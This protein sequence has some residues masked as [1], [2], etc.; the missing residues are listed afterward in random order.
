MSFLSLRRHQEDFDNLR[1]KFGLSRPQNDS[2]APTDSWFQDQANSLLNERIIP[3]L[4][5]KIQE[6]LSNPQTLFIS[7]FSI[8]I[9]ILKDSE[10]Y[11]D[12]DSDIPY[13][14][15]EEDDR[16]IFTFNPKKSKEES[17]SPMT[18]ETLYDCI[19][20]AAEDTE[21]SAE[22]FDFEGMACLE[23]SIEF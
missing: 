8:Q 7:K 13:F 14:A 1:E 6:Y 10:V 17:D 15:N 12:T 23:I 2:V 19:I 16:L 5:A 3:A 22:I 18:V 9:Y 4:D 20:K 21:V 11:L